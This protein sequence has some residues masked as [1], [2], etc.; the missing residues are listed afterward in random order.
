M[1]FFIVGEKLKALDCKILNSKSTSF[2]G[3]EGNHLKRS[4][5]EIRFKIKDDLLPRCITV[6]PRLPQGEAWKQ[7][8]WLV[9]L[10]SV[11]IS[12][13]SLA[14]LL[15]NKDAGHK[16]YCGQCL[17]VNHSKP[18]AIQE[19]KSSATPTSPA[20]RIMYLC[21]F[22]FLYFSIVA[23]TAIILSMALITAKTGHWWRGKSHLLHMAPPPSP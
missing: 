10:S 7:A 18:D 17:S 13:L 2:V 23:K 21:D 12:S 8:F 19:C 16:R 3:Q 1:I 9:L 4:L 15:A 14:K 20:P 11:V 5:K 6:Q 22:V